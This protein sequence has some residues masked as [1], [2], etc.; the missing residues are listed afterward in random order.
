MV[1]VRCRWQRGAHLLT[2]FYA[3]GVAARSRY[4]SL[5][6][7]SMLLPILSI[8]VQLLCVLGL[9]PVPPDALYKQPN[10]S[11]PDRV[12]DLIERMSL[13]EKAAQLGYPCG[14]G[15]QGC[16]EGILKIAPDGV[17]GLQTTSIECTNSLQAVLKNKTRLGIPAS[18]FAE[19]TH[20]GGAPGTTVFPMPCSQGASFNTSLVEQIA[21]INAL[22]LRSSGGD[23]GLSPILQVCTD[24]RWGIVTRTAAIT[25]LSSA[26]HRN[27]YRETSRFCFL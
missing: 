10:A 22:E 11:I 21:S 23:H 13:K 27:V 16:G 14:N 3:A 5:Q 15:Y 4:V 7:W 12:A 19:T 24:P 26:P 25:C 20:S 1:T 9:P 8:F 18:F 6:H 2:V 17:G